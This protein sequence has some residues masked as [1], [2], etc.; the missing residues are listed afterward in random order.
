MNDVKLDFAIVSDCCPVG[1]SIDV[2]LV[3]SRKDGHIYSYCWA[4]GAMWRHPLGARWGDT[5]GEMLD[6]LDHLP[7]GFA[8]PTD[9]EIITAGFTKYVLYKGQDD[10]CQ[11]YFETEL[12]ELNQC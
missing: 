11:K 7:Q 10:Y 12:N 9:T 2:F 1:C 3:I 6:P 8:L 5:A 4:C